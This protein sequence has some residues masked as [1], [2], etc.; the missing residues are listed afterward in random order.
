MKNAIKNAKQGM[1]KEI[2]HAVKREGGPD[3]TGTALFL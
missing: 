2:K 1:S 3:Y